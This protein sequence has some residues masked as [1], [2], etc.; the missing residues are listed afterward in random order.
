MLAGAPLESLSCLLHKTGST[1]FSLCLSLNLGSMP[2]PVCDWRVCVSMFV[3]LCLYL[4]QS[5]G[6]G[7]VMSLAGWPAACPAVSLRGYVHVYY[8]ALETKI[9]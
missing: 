3:S 9:N 4:C 8:E 5:P 6:C 2:V 7:Y 1:L